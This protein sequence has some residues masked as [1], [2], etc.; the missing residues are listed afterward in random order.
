MNTFIKVSFNS[1][2]FIL[3][4]SLTQITHLPQ[5]AFRVRT[6]MENLEKSWNFK[7]VISKPRKVMEKNLNHKSFGKVMKISYNHVFIYAEFEIINMFF[8]ERRRTLS[9]RQVFYIFHVYTEISVWSWTFGLKS[10]KSPG[11]ALVNI[12][13]NPGFTI[14]TH[15]HPRT[16]H[17]IR[18][19]SQE[20]EIKTVLQGKTFRRA[21]EDDPSPGWTEE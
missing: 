14:C 16:S 6:V 11:N 5:R 9:I 7:M 20:T 13:K 19:N 3:Y 10:W 15:R 12:C 21:T 2:Q 1:I 18:I 17:R 4:S 8:Q